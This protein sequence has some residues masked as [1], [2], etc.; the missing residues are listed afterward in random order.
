M[1]EDDHPGKS[2]AWRQ[3]LHSQRVPLEVDIGMQVHVLCSKKGHCYNPTETDLHCC[4]DTPRPERV[5]SRM[6]EPTRVLSLH[7]WWRARPRIQ[8]MQTRKPRSYGV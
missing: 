8:R 1:Y 5:T 4:I 3:R 7:G 6:N 2:D